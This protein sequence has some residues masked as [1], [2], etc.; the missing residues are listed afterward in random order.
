[1]GLTSFVVVV[2]VVFF[3]FYL[4]GLIGRAQGPYWENN[5]QNS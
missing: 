2:V 5:Y 3:F 4:L 1:M